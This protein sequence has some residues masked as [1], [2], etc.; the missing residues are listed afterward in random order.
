M[1]LAF[2]GRRYANETNSIALPAYATLGAFVERPLGR[3]VG[4]MVRLDNITGE[5]VED[6]YGYPVLGTTLSV[7]LSFSQ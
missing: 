1:S 4:L 2:T 5:R 6:T 3:G 7:R